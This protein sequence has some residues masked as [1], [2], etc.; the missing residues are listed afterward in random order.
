MMLLLPSLT[1]G[2]V[3]V[4]RHMLPVTI[5]LFFRFPVSHDSV[6]VRQHTQYQDPDA[7]AAK[8]QPFSLMVMVSLQITITTVQC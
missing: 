3:I 4:G 2:L 8:S 5:T 6:A 7:A 1:I